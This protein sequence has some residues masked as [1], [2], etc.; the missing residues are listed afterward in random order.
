MCIP[1]LLSSKPLIAKS[2]DSIAKNS[3]VL[4][5]WYD[6]GMMSDTTLDKSLLDCSNDTAIVEDWLMLG[7][8][9]SDKRLWYRAGE[10]M[11]ATIDEKSGRNKLTGLIAEPSGNFIQTYLL[12]NNK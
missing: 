1:T 7:E 8:L 6:L 2:L 11:A 12:L 4:K 3:A 5:P 9:S 10:K